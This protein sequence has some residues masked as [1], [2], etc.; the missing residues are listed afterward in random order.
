MSS[1]FA[2]DEDDPDTYFI[3][4]S[5]PEVRNLEQKTRVEIESKK[6]ELRTMVGEQYLELMS[7][8]D[9]IITM[10]KNTQ[11][12][13]TNICRMQTACNVERI[14]SNG[15]TPTGSTNKIHVDKDRQHVYL[16]ASLIKSLAD[17]PEQIWHALEHHQ[18]LHASRLYVLAKAAHDYLE[19]EKKTSALDIETKFPVIQ[20]Q[21]DAISAFESQIIQR[22]IHHLQISEQTPEHLSETLLGLIFLNELS[23][24]DALEKLLEMRKKVIQDLLSKRMTETPTQSIAR[25]LKEILAVF[26]HTF[27][28]VDSVFFS[29]KSDD[30]TLIETYAKHFQKTFSTPSQSATQSPITRLFSPS[31]NVH[32]IVRYLPESIQNYRPKLNPGS[33]LTSKDVEQAILS[34]TQTIERLVQD[35]LPAILSSLDTETSLVEVRSKVW[36]NYDDEILMTS[37]HL[38]STSY[39]VWEKLLR[40]FFNDQAKRIIEKQLDLLSSQPEKNVWPLIVSE[41][42][43]VMNNFAVTMNTWPGLSKAAFALPTCPKELELFKSGLTETVNDRTDILRK[44]QDLFDTLL[45]ELRKDAL[46]HLQ[47]FENNVFSVEVDSNYIKTYFKQKCYDSVIAYSSKLRLLVKRLEDWSDKKLASDVSLLIARLARNIALSSKELPKALAFSAETLPVFVLKSEVNKDPKYTKVQD[48]FLK[49]F[50]ETHNIWL[51]LLETSFSQ[52]LKKILEEMRWDDQCMSTW[53]SMEEDIKLPTQSTGTITRLVFFV[54]EEIRRINSCMLDQVIM[55][56]LR[57]IL[58]KRTNKIFQDVLSSKESEIT[59]YRA[60]QVIFDYLFLKTLL[61]Q[62]EKK[63]SLLEDDDDDVLSILEKKIDPINWESYKPYITIC[64][65]KFCIKQS[66]LFGVLTNAGSATY[67]RARKVVT[68]KQH[69]QSSISI[70][71]KAKTFVLGSI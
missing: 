33:S 37:Q 32:L 16:I 48:E 69:G 49:T 11:A 7:A 35:S 2:F 18:Y 51:L 23:Y 40:H 44:L 52:K 56:K 65:D 19:E 21:W 20:S 60:I 14:K 66:L 5:I 59:E 1:E 17:V 34:W 26:K 45:L 71:S 41:E 24:H 62:E 8:A 55:K 53:E 12:I 36:A 46:I 3:E 43:K 57:K 64:V 25:Q 70:A 58:Y 6:K 28:H 39:D 9:A 50:H 29:T 10:R 42:N 27:T 30:T 63:G 47:T 38:L 67:E 61:S 4:L 22:S 15:T 13:Q 54:C 31:S 68:E